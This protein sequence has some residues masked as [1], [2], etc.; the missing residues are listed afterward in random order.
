M[1]AEE[2]VAQI[3][4]ERLAVGAVV[5]GW[6]FH[7][8]KARS[9]TPAFLA[10]AGARHGFA[11]EIVAK[12]E[13]GAGES[14]R[15][16]SSTAIRRVLEC[17]DVEAAARGLGRYYAVS[18]RVVH[19]QRLGR[20]L[21]VPTANIALDPTTR[22]AHGIYAV[23]AKVDGKTAPGVASFGVRPTRRQRPSAAR[24]PSSGF[25]R[26]SL[27]ARDGS[28]IRPAHQGR[29]QVRFAGPARRGDE[30]RQGP[31][32]RNSGQNSTGVDSRKLICRF[33]PNPLIRSQLR[34]PIPISPVKQLRHAR[35]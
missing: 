1:N 10:D 31:S 34:P 27:R 13:E 17:G 9:G 4:V 3:L 26:G 5:V 28:G 12:V 8:G 16:L 19:G 7:F 22:L 18:G 11:V 35:S 25:Q 30:A 32:P 6:D 14:A 20:T 23:R 29:A 2:F 24:G 33:T 21:G 15:A